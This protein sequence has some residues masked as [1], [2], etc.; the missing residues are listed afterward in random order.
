MKHFVV[1]SSIY[2][3]TTT[4]QK[5]KKNNVEFF[6]FISKHYLVDNARLVNCQQFSLFLPSHTKYG[7]HEEKRMIAVKF[8]SGWIE[9]D[10]MR[11]VV[12]LN[13]PEHLFVH[14]RVKVKLVKCSHLLQLRATL[15]CSKE[16][17]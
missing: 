11:M 10:L 16:V 13:S 12:G 17:Y 1:A 6:L 7:K 14:V 4:I 3:A 9:M 2:T 5:S 15:P 8:T